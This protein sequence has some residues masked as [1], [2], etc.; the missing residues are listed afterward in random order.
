M[1]TILSTPVLA[2]E[3]MLTIPEEVTG[4]ITAAGQINT[5]TFSASAGGIVS[6]FA[7]GE[8]SFDPVIALADGS[9]RTL[10]VSDDYRYPDTRDALLE[11]V[12]LPRTGTYS[13]QVSGYGSSTGGYRLRLAPGFAQINAEET[14]ATSQGWELDGTLSGIVRSERLA[15]SVSGVRA[16]GAGFYQY[17]DP[18]ADVFVQVEVDAI[19]NP[20]GWT[21]GIA[22]RQTRDGYYALQVSDQGLW[23][24]VS[25]ADDAPQVIRDWTPHPNI[26]AGQTNFTLGLIANLQGFDFFYNRG[27]IGS[28]T[29]ATFTAP[30][31]VGV[32]LGTRSSL[33]STTTATFDNFI[34][35]TP[36]YIDGERIIPERIIVGAAAEMQRALEL[37]HRLQADGMMALT[38]P[39]STVAFARDGINRLMLGRGTTYTHFALAATVEIQAARSGLAGC[40]LV[41]RFTSENDYVLAYLDQT[42]G[43]GLSQRDGDGF[44]PGVYGENPNWGTDPVQLLIIADVSTLYYYIDG[45]YVGALES[46]ATA[47]EVGTAVVNYEA[48]NTTCLYRDIWLW[49]W[50]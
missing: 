46:T 12:T 6:I 13:I 21:A 5:Y 9:G 45:T 36:T 3:T 43:Y 2:Q 30:G 23:R 15:A 32:T 48:I 49:G 31:S 8:D 11:A 35:T 29:D 40:G 20:S 33:E 22:V 47:G 17:V 10:L 38:V 44:M 50:D 37:R 19:T 41:T 26:V 25:V 14:F 7:H 34:V 1:L 18:T 42:G 4:T 16:F 39:E 27:Y 28:V 24:F